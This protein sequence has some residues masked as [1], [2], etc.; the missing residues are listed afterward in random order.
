L[1]PMGGAALASVMHVADC[2][3]PSHCCCPIV[4]VKLPLSYCRPRSATVV[5]I[6]I[7]S[8]DS[9]GGIVTIAI[10]VAVIAAVFAI[11]IIAVIVDV[12]STTLLRHCC[13][14]VLFGSQS[15]EVDQTTPPQTVHIG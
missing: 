1:P 3:S 11:T 12:A 15:E 14:D 8:I 10:T 7:V 4:I 5:V 6:N 9:S 13:I 2:P